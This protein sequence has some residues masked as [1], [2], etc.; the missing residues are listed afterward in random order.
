[1][2]WGLDGQPTW[3][4]PR[5]IALSFMPVLF[6]VV[7]GALIVSTFTLTPRP[8]QEGYVLPAL[9]FVAAICVACHAFHLW[10]ISRWLRSQSR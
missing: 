1:M 4:A 2:Q 9:I 6:T 8:G 5:R 10:L 3:T 7:L